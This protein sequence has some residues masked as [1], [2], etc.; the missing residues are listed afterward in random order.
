MGRGNY[1]KKYTYLN[2]IKGDNMEE[3]IIEPQVEEAKEQVFEKVICPLFEVQV[4][5][6]SLRRRSTPEIAENVVGVITDR[7]I[8]KIYDER[9]GWGQLEDGSWIM[10]QY[11]KK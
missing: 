7:G 6:P 4:T 11:T 1:K 3:I 9:D 5:H 10:L 2:G 8:Y